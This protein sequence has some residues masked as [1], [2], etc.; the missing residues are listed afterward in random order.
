MNTHKKKPL[1]IHLFIWNYFQVPFCFFFFS[2]YCSTARRMRISNNGNKEQNWT[3]S[4]DNLL[5]ILNDL[6]FRR[7]RLDSMNPRWHDGLLISEFSV[8]NEMLTSRSAHDQSI[9]AFRI[10]DYVAYVRVQAVH[11]WNTFPITKWG[12][13]IARLCKMQILYANK[14]E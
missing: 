14:I 10:V 6:C 3:N 5:W 11:P 7:L 9:S 4:G 2:F 13:R 1:A 8:T 12:K